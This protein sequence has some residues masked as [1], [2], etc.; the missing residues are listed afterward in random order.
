[1]FSAEDFELSLEKSFKLAQLQ[2]EIDECN[3]LASIK[4]Q[5]K[6]SIRLVMGYQQILTKVMK[7]LI[8]KDLDGWFKDIDESIE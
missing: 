8:M 6:E 3:D 7:D 1:M 4:T 5:L 2:K